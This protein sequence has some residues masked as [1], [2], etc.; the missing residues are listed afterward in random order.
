MSNKRKKNRKLK[1]QLLNIFILICFTASAFLLYQ[2]I[3]TKLDEKTNR[4]TYSEI[5]EIFERSIRENPPLTEE[6]EPSTSPEPAPEQSDEPVVTE[7]PGQTPTTSPSLTPTPT[8][9]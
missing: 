8:P 6:P 1:R 2:A 5:E 9:T 3:I 7:F 4:E